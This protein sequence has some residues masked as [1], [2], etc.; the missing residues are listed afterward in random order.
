MDRKEDT[1]TSVAIILAA[2]SGSRMG[3]K[4]PK[5]LHNINGTSI[6]RMACATFEACKQ[7]SATVVVVQPEIQDQ[8]RHVLT[9][10]DKVRTVLNGGETRQ[11]SCFVALQWISKHCKSHYVLVHDAARPFV[12]PETI[13]ACIQ[14]LREH[15][16]VDV[17]YP[18]TDTIVQVQNGFVTHIPPRTLMH[19]GQTPQ[20]FHT[21]T[22]LDAYNKYYDT[23]HSYA[24]ATDDCGVLRAT[25]PEV[26]IK[27]VVGKR[28]NIKITYPEDVTRAE[29]VLNQYST[30]PTRSDSFAHLKG[31][32]LVVVGGS[33]GIGHCVAALA[34]EHGA[35]VT[36]LSR[37]VGGLDITD[38]QGVHDA[39]ERIPS[40]DYVVVTAG[41]LHVGPLCTQ[42][43]HTDVVQTIATNF[44][45]AAN[46][47]S[48]AYAKLLQTSG[49]LIFFGS[50]S[51]SQGRPNYAVYSATKAAVVNLTQALGE[52]WRGQVRV[53][54]VCPARTRT[55]MRLQ[56]F[57]E[58]DPRTLL[59]PEAVARA[60]LMVLGA[61]A[62]GQTFPIR[63]S[64]A[65]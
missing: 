38:A 57:G 45:G 51:Y 32:Q 16:A 59:S 11:E 6:V 14:E 43:I 42:N 10:L 3:S 44:T 15:K 46:V 63:I 39:F 28:S 22:I 8:V 27:A 50:S 23:N 34:T 25:Y 29:H 60:A 61:T 41:T 65:C 30:M 18:S 49:H 36:V 64:D 26:A 7:I 19:C 33:S 54:C 47:A 56:A 1:A 24:A 12:A 31:K 52:E 40:I 62:S 37:T 17:T 58:E 5:Q 53:N 2:G 48:A 4:T 9:G 55:N 35:H 21:Q 20:G 13:Q